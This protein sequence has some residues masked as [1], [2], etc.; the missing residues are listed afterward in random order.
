MVYL[1]QIP[2]AHICNRLNYKL[3]FSN[4]RA[5]ALQAKNGG[6]SILPGVIMLKIFT[7]LPLTE[8]ALTRLVCRR[9]KILEDNASLTLFF[10]CAINGGKKCSQIS[11]IYSKALGLPDN[12]E[13]AFHELAKWS[14]RDFTKALFN[15]SCSFADQEMKIKSW[16][17]NR[18]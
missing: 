1:S 8:F 2:V 4:D 5:N 15:I 17:G 13:K 3:D 16:F 11:T 6:C 12:Q 18:C 7:H 14:D 9:W 10:L